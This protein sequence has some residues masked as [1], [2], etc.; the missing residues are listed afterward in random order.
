M[1]ARLPR[2]ASGL[3]NSVQAVLRPRC[4]LA[5][6]QSAVVSRRCLHQTAL[7]AD[8]AATPEAPEAAAAPELNVLTYD[9]KPQRLEYQ[10]VKRYQNVRP[11]PLAPFSVRVRQPYIVNDSP[12]KLD[13]MY[14][15][16]FGT[17]KFNLPDDLKWQAVTHKSFD[18]G[19]QPYNE[20]LMFMGTSHREI[21]VPCKDT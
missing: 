21:G 8:E 14:R 11:Q 5:S 1:A 20:K 16:L 4:L 6:T 13:A 9:Q 12:K 17:D 15:E 18:H 3:A 7:V 10:P 19:R 2:T